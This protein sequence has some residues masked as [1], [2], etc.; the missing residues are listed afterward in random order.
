MKK[1][2]GFCNFPLFNKDY[3]RF[4]YCVERTEV[5]VFLNSKRFFQFDSPCATWKVIVPKTDCGIYHTPLS[6][7]EIVQK[8]TKQQRLHKVQILCQN[9]LWYILRTPFSHRNSI[10]NKVQYASYLAKYVICCQ[11]N[12]RTKTKCQLLRNL[13]FLSRNVV[14]NIRYA[15]FHHNIA[16][17]C[18]LNI[19]KMH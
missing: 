14:C 5:Y 1:K 10:E 15:F 18:K 9:P 3:I 12:N 16:D 19:F 7:T 4:K 11:K 2:I 17:I 13:E 6:Q 8:I